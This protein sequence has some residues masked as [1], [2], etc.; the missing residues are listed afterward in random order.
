M[1][2][3]RLAFRRLLALA[4]VAAILAAAGPAGAGDGIA[5]LGAATPVAEDALADVRGGF[6]VAGRPLAFS[7]RVLTEVDGR[8]VERAGFS[9]ERLEAAGTTAPRRLPEGV[10]ARTGLTPQAWSMLV[11]N[12]RDGITIR[13]LADLQVDVVLNRPRPTD[14][15]ARALDGV[16]L[17]RLP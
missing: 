9:S 8:V 10:A 17:F 15:A 6:T 4:A 11:E 2:R 12:R 16:L 3:H 5:G 1:R 14:A 7:F 13:Q